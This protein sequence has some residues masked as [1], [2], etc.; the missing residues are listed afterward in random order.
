MFVMELGSKEFATAFLKEVELLS[1]CIQVA[2]NYIQIKLFK[3]FFVLP[4][5]FVP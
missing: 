5:V 4:L 2:G 3:V 1:K